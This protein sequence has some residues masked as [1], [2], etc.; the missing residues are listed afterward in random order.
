MLDP[1]RNILKNH[2]IYTKN[3]I[4]KLEKNN[5]DKVHI[6][7]PTNTTGTG[8]KNLK[9]LEDKLVDESLDKLHDFAAGKARDHFKVKDIIRF[10]VVCHCK[11][12]KENFADLIEDSAQKYM[13]FDDI[14]REK[15]EGETY[16]AIHFDMYK[17]YEYK[18]KKILVPCEVQV[19]TIFEHAQAIQSHKYH[20][21]QTEYGEKSRMYILKTNR[22]ILKA[23]EE[24]V[25]W[26]RNLANENK[27]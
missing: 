27:S 18:K 6:H 4:R 21:K 23:L 9:S 5:K 26:I 2:L 16:D 13:N 11:I 14:Y 10:R 15:K 22:L 12:D 8:F 25:E 19:K 7:E 1:L 3:Q 17:Y 24:P 20:Y